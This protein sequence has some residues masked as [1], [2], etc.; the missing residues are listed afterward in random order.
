MTSTRKRGTR[1]VGPVAA[2]TRR[3]GGA[4]R[5]VVQSAD[6]RLSP[7]SGALW[8]RVQ[9]SNR[10]KPV[11]NGRRVGRRIV[12]QR[13]AVPVPVRRHVESRRGDVGGSHGRNEF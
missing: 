3:I 10:S 8:G 5:S 11:R 12:L 7:A 4:A 2:G 9:P 1:H 13:E 6:V